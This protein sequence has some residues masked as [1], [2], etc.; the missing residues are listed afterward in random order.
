VEGKEFG[1]RRHQGNGDYSESQLLRAW[2]PF[3]QGGV[4]EN[5]KALLD[6]FIKSPREENAEK[7]VITKRGKI[8]K[9]T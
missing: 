5:Q 1:K 9:S 6:N 3:S 4:H 7:E 8:Q 2:K